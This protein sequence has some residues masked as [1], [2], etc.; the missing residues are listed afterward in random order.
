MAATQPELP[1]SWAEWI[2]FRA[3]GQKKDAVAIA[4]L[5]SLKMQKLYPGAEHTPVD[6][7][8]VGQWLIGERAPATPELHRGLMHVLGL[9]YVPSRGSRKKDV[10]VADVGKNLG[11]LDAKLA[12]WRE[13][14]EAL[15]AEI[16]AE[17]K[18][19]E[20]APPSPHRVRKAGECVKI[21][22]NLGLKGQ[23][24]GELQKILAETRS[25]AEY[26]FC[27]FLLQGSDWSQDAFAELITGSPENHG[28]VGSYIRGEAL[29]SREMLPGL[30]R[31]L[32]ADY[33]RLEALLI[34]ER[35]AIH[36]QAEAPAKKEMMLAQLPP[37]YW[38]T[39]L[40][41]CPG[42]TADAPGNH[43]AHP[44]KNP[45]SNDAL[46][47]E[48]ATPIQTRKS[49]LR[50]LRNA[51]G[52]TAEEVG[53]HLHVVAHYVLNLES[54]GTPHSLDS[55]GGRRMVAFYESGEAT[56]LAAQKP[57]RLL[58]S[59]DVQ[60]CFK[61]EAYERLEKEALT[62]AGATPH[63]DAVPAHPPVPHVI[64]A[65]TKRGGGLPAYSNAPADIERD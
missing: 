62:E 64:A 47:L 44:C 54:N 19:A 28:V 59:S 26:I 6:P 2:R 53:H 58:S 14:I 56:L 31:A 63:D 37:H 65:T 20:L 7:A 60:P 11:D 15:Y 27:F 49:Y 9:S 40:A 29:P 12:N 18:T 34:G 10:G 24:D 52:L 42:Q 36:A 39:V 38:T 8:L 57:G 50:A 17:R 30:K 45:N 3:T 55:P 4:A 43:G 25:V 46:W 41:S 32:G 13:T 23:S 21:A 5:L 35:L 61:R 1:A 48:A 33:P 16:P 22:G 51:L